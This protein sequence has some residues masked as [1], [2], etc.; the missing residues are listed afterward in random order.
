MQS[1]CYEIDTNIVFDYYKFDIKITKRKNK[2]KN[3]RISKYNI[4]YKL[5]IN[6]NY[7]YDFINVKI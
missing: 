4:K 6:N 5:I 7:D 3:L 1:N 2:S